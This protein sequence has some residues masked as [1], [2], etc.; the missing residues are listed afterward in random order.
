MRAWQDQRTCTGCGHEARLACGHKQGTAGATH[1]LR[2][3][4]E[5][6][7]ADRERTAAV[8]AESGAHQRRETEKECARR[9]LRRLGIGEETRRASKG[10]RS[11]RSYE[12]VAGPRDVHGVRSRGALGPRERAQGSAGAAYELRDDV[13]ADAGDQMMSA[14]VPAG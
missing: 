9:I 6:D 2:V 8:P 1:I 11:G 14:A 7:A 4:D 13:E 12:G 10:A 3:G 5:A